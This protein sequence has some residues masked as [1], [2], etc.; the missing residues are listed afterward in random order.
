[1][2]KIPSPEEARSDSFIRLKNDPVPLLIT[3]SLPCTSNPYDT[4]GR[5]KIRKRGDTAGVTFSAPVSHHACN[6]S[7]ASCYI[8]G[9]NA[10]GSCMNPGAFGLGCRSDLAC[11]DELNPWDVDFS[12]TTGDQHVNIYSDIHNCG[13]C[14]FRCSTDEKC[15][16]LTGIPE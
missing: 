10:F 7:G 1:M 3:G 12:M 16:H 5:L 11:N 2:P 14:G 4:V 6:C 15:D 13:S 9:V 8:T